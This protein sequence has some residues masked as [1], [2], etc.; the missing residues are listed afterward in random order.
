MNSYIYL[1][2]SLLFIHGTTSL[3]TCIPYGDPC[4]EDCDCCGWPNDENVRCELRNPKRGLRCHLNRQIDEPCDGDAQCASQMCV[5][6]K[7]S[8]NS[9]PIIPPDICPLPIT[10]VETIK[11]SI[12]D[13][14]GTCPCPDPDNPTKNDAL[15]AVDGELSTVYANNYALNSGLIFY[16]AYPAPV[17]NMTICSADDCPECDPTCYKLEGYCN[18]MQMITTIQEGDIYFTQRNECVTIPVT[19]RGLFSYYALTFPCQRGG[20]PECTAPEEC[21][22]DNGIV[23]FEPK[24]AKKEPCNGHDP[25][26][27]RRLERLPTRSN[28]IVYASPALLRMTSM[29]PSE[30]ESVD[31]APRNAVSTL[32]KVGS[33]TRMADTPQHPL[34]SY[35]STTKVGDISEIVY[36]L[37]N[38]N[39]FTVNHLYTI[40]QWG[41]DCCFDCFTTYMDLPKNDVLDPWDEECQKSCNSVNDLENLLIRED[42]KNACFSIE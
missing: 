37:E 19:T 26:Q 10:D 11:G 24:P 5:N 13:D 29:L 40:I 39:G 41:G 6:G 14:D 17:H 23:P 15:K 9:R 21:T 31:T 7:C 2:L 28:D 25:V 34:L 18:Q 22:C 12:I 38:L 1:A 35:V 36:K 4:S 42:G 27:S 16:T 30:R 8:G 3:P 32:R 33:F 20:F